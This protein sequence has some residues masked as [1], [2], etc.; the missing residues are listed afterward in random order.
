VRAALLVAVALATCACAGADLQGPP[1]A[2]VAA[3]ARATAF[4]TTSTTLDADAAALRRAWSE[5]QGLAARTVCLAL[6][7]DAQQANGSLPAPDRQ[8]TV[9]LSRAYQLFG[10]AAA[11]CSPPALALAERALAAARARLASLARGRPG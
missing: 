4:A 3:W 8:L 6:G 5:G 9:Q 10:Q 11:S 2:R 7:D 1:A